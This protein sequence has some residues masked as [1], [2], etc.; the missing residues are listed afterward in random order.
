MPFKTNITQAEMQ[1]HVQNIKTHHFILGKDNSG[2][3]FRSSTSIGHNL[4]KASPTVKVQ[5]PNNQA[6]HFTL[7]NDPLTKTSDYNMRYKSV[8]FAPGAISKMHMRENQM[9][10]H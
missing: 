5:N 9:R 8:E 7:G 4:D 1:G 3:G 6:T 2:Q 10:N